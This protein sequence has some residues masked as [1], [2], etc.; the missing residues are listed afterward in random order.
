MKALHFRNKLEESKNKVFVREGHREKDN[1][2]DL[3]IQNKQVSLNLVS[4]V[5]KLRQH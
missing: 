3:K 2:G 4:L 1:H 5:V